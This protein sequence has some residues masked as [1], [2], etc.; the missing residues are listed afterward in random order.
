MSNRQDSKI[1]HIGD[2]LSVTTRRLVS[3]RYM[4]GVYDLVRYLTDSEPQLDR[5]ADT[6]AVC[7][8][9]LLELHPQFE[10][11]NVDEVEFENWR[12]WLQ[13]Q[14]ATHGEWIE[15]RHPLPGEVA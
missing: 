7:K 12:N 5:L 15:V 4:D 9:Y 14:Q 3:P 10:D 8:R 2:V 11:L 6:M 1:F 13:A